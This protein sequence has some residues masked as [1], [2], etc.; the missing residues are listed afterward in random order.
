MPVSPCV[1]EIDAEPLPAVATKDLG[2]AGTESAMLGPIQE[3][4][5]LLLLVSE[6]FTTR[7][8]LRLLVLSLNTAL[9]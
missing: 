4:P 5:T 2:A 6:P 7:N 9:K 1:N 8:Q 3:Q